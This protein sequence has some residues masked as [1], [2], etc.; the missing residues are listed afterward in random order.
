M[1]QVTLVR[2]M[3]QEK[4]TKIRLSKHFINNK[5]QIISSTTAHLIKSLDFHSELRTSIHQ[6][7]PTW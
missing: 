5:K 7:R 1:Q 2:F 3:K 6:L 4:N